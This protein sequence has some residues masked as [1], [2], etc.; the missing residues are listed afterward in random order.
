M[1]SE[2]IP[3]LAVVAQE[4]G[5]SS[6][7][8]NISHTSSSS[9]IAFPHS[10]IPSAVQKFS[11]KIQ[12]FISAT[13]VVVIKVLTDFHGT[14]THPSDIIVFCI[15]GQFQQPFAFKIYIGS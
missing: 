3:K 4:G 9:T 2:V 14:G 8:I 6:L 7:L 10:Q 5:P 11:Q 13:P 15:F 1:M 12:N